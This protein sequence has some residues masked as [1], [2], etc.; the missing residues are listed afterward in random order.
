MP[1]PFARQ[2]WQMDQEVNLMY[3]AVTR[4]KAELIEVVA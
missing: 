2:Q 3:V 4:A 1:S